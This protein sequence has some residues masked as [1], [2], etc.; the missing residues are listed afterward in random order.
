MMIFFDQSYVFFQFKTHKGFFIWL[1]TKIYHLSTEGILLFH[2]FFIIILLRNSTKLRIMLRSIPKISNK[3]GNISC[4]YPRGFWNW[5]RFK[6]TQILYNFQR[7]SRYLSFFTNLVNIHLVS[8]PN[9][10]QYSMFL[11]LDKYIF[12]RFQERT[13]FSKRE[14]IESYISWKHQENEC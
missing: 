7:K 2:C 13:F 12:Y 14:C 6:C 9:N 11:H 4:W 3:I 5:V 8:F 1:N 10:V